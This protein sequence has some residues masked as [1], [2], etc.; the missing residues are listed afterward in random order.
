MVTA[1]PTGKPSWSRETNI[2]DYGGS[3]DKTDS[4]TEGTT[5]YAYSVYREIIAMK[6][7]AYSSLTGTLVH[8]Q[9]LAKARLLGFTSFRMPEMLRSNA[10][11][12][13]SDDGLDYW[14]KVLAVPA[15]ASDQK[16][17]LRQR[18]AAHYKAVTSITLDDIETAL[19][20]LLGGV[21]VNASFQAGASLAAPPTLTYWP[22]VNVGPATYSLGRGC[23]ASERSH[24][25][26]EVTRP[27]S[28]PAGE[29]DQLVNVQMYQLLDR[30][31]PAFCTFGWATGTGFLLDISQLDFVGLGP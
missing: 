27:S 4:V 17:Q 9:N 26:V 12:G 19:A 14:V 31:L 13:S 10:L 20:D 6:G 3:S 16:W 22:G 8:C 28:M 7:S 24:L 25:Y 11:P 29:F 15:K 2:G 18:C 30:Q 21:F 1:V 5:P 23:W